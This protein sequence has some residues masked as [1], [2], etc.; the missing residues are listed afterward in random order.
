MTARQRQQSANRLVGS[1]IVWLPVLLIPFSVF[2][3]ETWMQLQI[4]DN[5]Y[6]I[7]AL[8]TNLNSTELSIL[9]LEQQAGQFRAVDVIDETAPYLG[10]IDPE[11]GQIQVIYAEIDAAEKRRRFP[12]SF[13]RVLGTGRPGG[14]SRPTAQ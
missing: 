8:Q 11:P 13:A 2:F 9:M 7:S 3:A 14:A 1:M 4:R 10:M 6:E 12:Y 5:D